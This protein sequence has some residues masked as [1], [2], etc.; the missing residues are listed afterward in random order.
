MRRL[1]L[2]VGRKTFMCFVACMFLCNSSDLSLL[3]A[4]LAEG[5]PRGFPRFPKGFPMGFQGVPHK[6]KGFPLFR[7]S[8]SRGFLTIPGVIF[9]AKLFAFIK[10]KAQ[11][12]KKRPP[13][14]IWK[15]GFRILPGSAF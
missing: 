6:R 1:L 14:R 11:M 5:F 12:R 9:P 2:L 10:L 8:K 4:G 7:P 13:P 3:P 15:L